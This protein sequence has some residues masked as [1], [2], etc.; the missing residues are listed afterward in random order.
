MGAAGAE[1]EEHDGPELHE[2]D[3]YKSLG[4]DVATRVTVQGTRAGECE[5]TRDVPSNS[6]C[7]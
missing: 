3:G 6:R 2:K 1:A 4:N 7:A 5:L